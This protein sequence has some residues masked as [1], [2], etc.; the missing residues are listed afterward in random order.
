MDVQRKETIKIASP[1]AR[2]SRVTAQETWSVL[3][4][5]QAAQQVPVLFLG[6]SVGPSLL[7]TALLVSALPGGSVGLLDSSACLRA[8]RQSLLIYA[9]GGRSLVYLVNF[10]IF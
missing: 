3:D 10:K 4:N 1:K 9:W 2:S 5:L 8:P 7:Q 6:S